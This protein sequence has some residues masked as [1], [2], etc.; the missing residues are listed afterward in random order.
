MPGTAIHGVLDAASGRIL[1][2]DSPQPVT[3]QLLAATAPLLPTQVLRLSAPCQKEACGHFTGSE[4]SLVD[5]LVQIL[6]ATTKD[7]PH[8]AIRPAC[9]WFR[10]RAAQACIRCATIVTDEFVRSKAMAELAE[11][12]P[13]AAET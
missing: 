3:P 13:R 11:P 9:R 7:L 8:C 4:C 5:R 10:E 2:L 6:P 12:R 1:Y